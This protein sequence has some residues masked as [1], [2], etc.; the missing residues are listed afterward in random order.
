MATE[1][2]IDYVH[3]LDPSISFDHLH[4]FTVKQ[5]Q[6]IITYLKAKK[7]ADKKQ[8]AEQKLIEVSVV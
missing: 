2:H 7:Q 1:S 6:A 3:L 4:T 5:A 8:E